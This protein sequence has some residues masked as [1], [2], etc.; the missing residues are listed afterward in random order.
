VAKVVN[1]EEFLKLP[2]GTIYCKGR[3]WYF[4]GICIKRNSL[5]NEWLYCNPAWVDAEGRD[6]AL[7]RVEDSL[8]NGTAYPCERGM[9]RDVAADEDAL[10]L[11][12]DHDDLL[13]LREQID[14][15]IRKST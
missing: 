9:S 5:A 10:F 4:E 11:V 8:A 12:F 6:E 2:S 13:W 3:R 1:R 7:A 14:E 15:A